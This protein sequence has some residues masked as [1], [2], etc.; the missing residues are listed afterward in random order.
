MQGM[1]GVIGGLLFRNVQGRTVVSK[2]PSELSRSQKKRQSP[3]QELNRGRFRNASYYARAMMLD[4]RMKEYY[5]QRAR[6]L[7][8]PNGY[9]AAI[10]DFM[11]KTSVQSVN[12]KRYTGKPGGNISI[13]ASKKDFAVAEVSVTLTSSEGQVIEKGAAVRTSTGEW[14]YKNTAPVALPQAVTITVDAKDRVGNR[15]QAVFRGKEAAQCR[16][17]RAGWE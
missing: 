13:T 12:T 15:T 10:A 1:T 2:C 5:W 3:L 14:I 7:K 6:K 9:T 16:Y 4:P 8:L 17:W 11:R